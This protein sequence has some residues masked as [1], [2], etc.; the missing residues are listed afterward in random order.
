[1]LLAPARRGSH[2]PGQRRTHHRASTLASLSELQQ[3]QSAQQPA[4][5]ANPRLPCCPAA[6]PNDLDSSKAAFIMTPGG[7]IAVA[8][9]GQASLSTRN[10]SY[11]ER[12]QQFY[13]EPVNRSLPAAGLR[14]RSAQTGQYCTLSAGAPLTCSEAQQGSATVYQYTAAGLTVD[15]GKL[16]LAAGGA[17]VVVAPG[18][19]TDQSTMLIVMYPGEDRGRQGAQPSTGDASG[20]AGAVAHSHWS[21]HRIALAKVLS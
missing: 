9:S 17:N 4:V 19:G 14:L 5:L 21:L 1:M 11:Q 8:S 13:I 3:R 7:P 15:S 16:A 12:A 2:G 18:S 20:L 6:L 10:V